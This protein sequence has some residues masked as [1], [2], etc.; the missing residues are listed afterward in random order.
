MGYIF[1][2]VI[3]RRKGKDDVVKGCRDLVAYGGQ[4]GGDDWHYADGS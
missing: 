2:G 4:D 3:R 1:R